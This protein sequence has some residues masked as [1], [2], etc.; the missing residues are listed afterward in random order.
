V[1]VAFYPT[2]R[3]ILPHAAMRI[4]PHGR[5]ILPHEENSLSH[6][7]ALQRTISGETIPTE[8]GIKSRTGGPRHQSAVASLANLPC[9]ILPEEL[10]ATEAAAE[11]IVETTPVRNEDRL[12]RDPG[13]CKHDCGGAEVFGSDREKAR[14][15]IAVRVTVA[16]ANRSASGWSFPN[17]ACRWATKSSLATVTM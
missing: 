2:S 13:C 4:L 10:G 1:S 17:A 11:G 9:P 15:K 16:I 8:N 12:G 5:F 6:F 3:S 14:I 7:V